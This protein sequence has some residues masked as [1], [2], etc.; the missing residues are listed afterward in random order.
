MFEYFTEYRG[1][2]VI[3][4]FAALNIPP[5]DVAFLTRERIYA[6]GMGEETMELLNRAELESG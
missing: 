5:S 1:R 6:L 3:P 4:V 2:R